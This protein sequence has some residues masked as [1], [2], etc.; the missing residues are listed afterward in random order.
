MFCVY[1]KVYYLC[2][3][4]GEVFLHCGNNCGNSSNG[5]DR[6]EAFV[7]IEKPIVKSINYQTFLCFDGVVAEL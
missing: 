7:R 2:S 6:R 1:E 5:T 3:V 4:N